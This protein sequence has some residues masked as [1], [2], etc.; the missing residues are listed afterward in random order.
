MY[1]KDPHICN[2]RLAIVEFAN[3]FRFASRRCLIGNASQAVGEI[4]DATLQRKFEK[5]FFE[6]L[7]GNSTGLR[8]QLETGQFRHHLELEWVYDSWRA[9]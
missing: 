8:I 5:I 2:N 7:A 6:S 1:A 9:G 4:D 3:N